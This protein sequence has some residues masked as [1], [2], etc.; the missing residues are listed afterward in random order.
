MSK[1]R[2]SFSCD[3]ET[4]DQIDEAAKKNNTSRS[5]VVRL[6]LDLVHVVPA[7]KLKQTS[8]LPAYFGIQDTGDKDG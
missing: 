3:P 7:D 4:I 8:P 6:L 2:Y 5:A 1:G